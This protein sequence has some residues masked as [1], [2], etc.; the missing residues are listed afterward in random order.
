FYTSGGYHAK[1]LQPFDLAKAI[2]ERPTYV[3]FNGTEGALTGPNALH[4]KVGEKIRLFVGNGGPNLASNFHVIGVIFDRVHREG[5][6]STDGNV[7]TTVVPA[8]G[9][10]I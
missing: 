1:G 3:L 4:A 2:D 9:A 7:Q 6:S 8:G 10:S 5:G